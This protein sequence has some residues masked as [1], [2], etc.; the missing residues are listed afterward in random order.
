[1]FVALVTHHAKRMSHIILSHMACLAPPY[2]STL[3]QRHDFRG[4]GGGGCIEHTCQFWL[5]LQICL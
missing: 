3:S 2:L 4:G 5:S 1:V